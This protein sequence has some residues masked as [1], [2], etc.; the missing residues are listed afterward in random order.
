MLEQIAVKS[1]PAVDAFLADIKPIKDGFAK[2]KNAFKRKQPIHKIN[3]NRYEF[4]IGKLGR[5]GW[6]KSPADG[7]VMLEQLEAAAL[8]DSDTRFRALIEEKYNAAGPRVGNG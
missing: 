4:D 7:V 2:P 6:V 5:R 1:N 3:A 8:D